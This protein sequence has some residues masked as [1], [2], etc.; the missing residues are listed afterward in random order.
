MKIEECINY[1]LTQS[2]IKINLLF[3][4]NLSEYGITPAQYVLLYH[5]WEED[6][7]SPTQLAALSGLDASTVTGL[8]TR[9]E[10]KGLIKRKHS[11]D[12]R[13]GVNVWLTP[14][15]AALQSDIERVIEASNE[16][17]LSGMSGKDR[18]FLKDCLKRM[19]AR[20]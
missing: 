8:L 2:Q 10:E 17:V 5:L 14:Q 7:L 18:E 6:G 11:K 15:G 4:A 1:L 3:R 13:R 20:A 9:M 19:C 16:E 12:D